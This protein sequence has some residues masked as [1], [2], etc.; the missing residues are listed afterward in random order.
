[1]FLPALSGLRKTVAFRLT[2][3]HA[4]IFVT[5]L[6]VLFLIVYFTLSRSLQNNDQEL[7]SAELKEVS[8]E[9]GEGGIPAVS[10]LLSGESPLFVVR[11]ADAHNRTLFVTPSI[12]AELIARLEKNPPTP[13]E[14]WNVLTVP[15]GG[16]LEVHS[17]KLPDGAVLQVG[18]STRQR[19]LFL[20][21]FR[22]VCAAIIAPMIVLGICGGVL[23]ARRTLRPLHDLNATVHRIIQTGHLGER[24]PVQR[25]PGEL[26]EL[27]HSFNQMLGRIETLIRSMRDSLDNVA[28]E[29][30]TPMT[31]LRATA[32]TALRDPFN[33]TLAQNAL[34]EC[35]EECEQ[36]MT[37]LQTVTDIAEAEAGAM[38][39]NLEL[40]NLP[41]LAQ[42]VADLYQQVAEDK[43]IEILLNM[44]NTLILQADNGRLPQVVANLI[45]NAVKYTPSGGRIIL[46]AWTNNGEVALSV[47]DS[48]IGISLAESERVWERLYRAEKSRSV[49][50]MGLGLAV[51]KAIVESHRGRVTLESKPNHGSTFTIFLPTCPSAH[52]KDRSC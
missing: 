35:V 20:L 11:I 26:A 37:L 3:W 32:E 33:A 49:K 23:F 16:D 46:S 38:K 31:R 28:H 52:R 48:G 43:G 27:V 34:A 44:P 10:K 14:E 6:V 39:L 40:V 22:R 47:K 19:Q 21:R 5:S 36:T 12:A 41:F 25:A 51:V 50:G 24:I 9:Y 4:T 8:E 18:R 30:R 29:L 2:A 42:R 15:R 17:A 1:M 7:A 13:S 45:D